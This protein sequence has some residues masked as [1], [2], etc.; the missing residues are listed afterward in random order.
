MSAQQDFVS[1]QPHSHDC[2]ASRLAM[3]LTIYGL[4]VWVAYNSMDALPCGR[5]K[6]AQS[7]TER[8]LSKLT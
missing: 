3:L 2:V 6:R 1:Q 7:H 5:H 8:I 4:K